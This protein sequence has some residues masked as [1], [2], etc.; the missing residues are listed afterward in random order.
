MLHSTLMSASHV[1]ARKWLQAM[2]LTE[3][4][5]KPIRAHHLGRILNVSFKT[6]AS[7][8][9][10]MGGATRRSAS[11]LD[12][13]VVVACRA[14]VFSIGPEP[15]VSWPSTSAA[16]GGGSKGTCFDGAREADYEPA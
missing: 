10:R 4:G 12:N 3:G 6:A 13:N 9:R 15:A 2:Y 14:I 11:Y 1:P 5:T 16:G 8:M 7:M